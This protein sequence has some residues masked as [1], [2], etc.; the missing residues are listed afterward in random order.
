MAISIAYEVGSTVYV[1]YPF[2]S[3]LYWLP[4]TRVVSKIQVVGSGDLV[5]VSF[6]SGNDVTDSDA[7]PTVF[8][9]QVACATAI[10]NDIIT[11]AGPVVVLDT[12]TTSGASTAGQVATTLI[13][14]S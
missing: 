5:N 14:K 10:V 1:R 11:N 6:T 3:S 2:T 12:A 8:T 7:T 4:Q 13:R 9:T